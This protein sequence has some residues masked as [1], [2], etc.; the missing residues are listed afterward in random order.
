MGYRRKG[1]VGTRN[2]IALCATVNCSAT[3]IRRA[4][5]EIMYSGLLKDY[6]NV[7]GVVAFAHGTGCAMDTEGPGFMTT[8]SGCCG[9]MPRIRMSARR[10]SSGW[11]AR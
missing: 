7:D 11:A 4:A 8:C 6:P 2:M 9:A 3:V 10:S 1:Q 5:D